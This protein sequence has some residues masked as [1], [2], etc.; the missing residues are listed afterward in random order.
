MWFFLAAI[1]LLLYLYLSLNVILI[2][3]L[4]SNK[5][6]LESNQ[7]AWA[8]YGILALEEFKLHFQQI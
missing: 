2:C 7:S 5:F 6:H 3:F 8:A 1:V 4:I